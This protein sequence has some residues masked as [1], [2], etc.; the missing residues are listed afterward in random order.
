MKP[1]AR[2]LIG[3]VVIAVVI[4]LV[5]G[6]MARAATGRASTS[7]DEQT[8]LVASHLACPVCQ[9]LA[10]SDSPSPLAGQ[11]RALIR[12]KLQAGES[13]DA[14]EQYFVDAYGDTILIEPPR[15][16]FWLLIWWVPIIT[17]LLSA[18]VLVAVLSQWLKTGKQQDDAALPQLSAD[19]VAKY[20]AWLEHEL[21]RTDIE[22]SG[23]DRAEAR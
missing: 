12:E 19:D 22:A 11:M 2:S 3:L 7:L 23:R 15:R 18:G 10:V 13:P 16:G 17:V 4:L 8:R 9:G 21:A 5:L 14:I 20:A 1:D 6:N